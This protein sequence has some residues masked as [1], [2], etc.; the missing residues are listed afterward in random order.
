MILVVDDD[1]DIRELL[2]SALE[3]RGFEVQQASNGQ[4]AI[5]VLNAAPHPCLVLLDLVMPGMDGWAVIAQMKARAIDDVPVCVMTA[6]PEKAPAGVAATLRKPF[7]LSEL[8]AVAQR[9]CG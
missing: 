1:E 6:L 7:E 8:V 5:D 9:Y 2:A 4:A 3:S